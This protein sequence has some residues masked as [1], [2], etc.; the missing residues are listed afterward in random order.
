MRRKIPPT[1]AAQPRNRRPDTQWVP[2]GPE[3]PVGSWTE[4]RPGDRIIITSPWTP[5]WDGEVDLVTNDG[6]ILWVHLEA[7]RGRILVQQSD[8]HQVW[9]MPTGVPASPLG[10]P[11]PLEAP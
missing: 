4:L 5:R 8:G 7:G 2:P 9:R 10:A 11:A 3:A 6:S 1:H